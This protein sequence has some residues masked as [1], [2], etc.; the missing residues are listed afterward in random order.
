M[1]RDTFAVPRAPEHTT[2][3][4]R[5]AVEHAAQALA[6]ADNAQHECLGQQL[7]LALHSRQ[8]FWVDTCREVLEMRTPSPQVLE[9][10]QRHGCRF[11]IP[12]PRQVQYILDA[13]DAALPGWDR[14]HPELFYQ[15]L[16]LNF[17]E[18]LRICRAQHRN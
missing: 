13:L 7:E 16:E 17:R 4:V 10:H 11:C 6:D 3:H 8:Q 12:A 5:Q 14:D 15:T 2:C 18:L 9:L 1:P